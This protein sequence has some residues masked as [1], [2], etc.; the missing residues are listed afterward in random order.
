[1]GWRLLAKY[2][3]IDLSEKVSIYDWKTSR[4]KPR[5]KWLAE[6]V[7]TRLYPYLLVK[8]GAYLRQDQAIQ[9]EQVQMVYWFSEFPDQPELFSYTTIQYETD[10]QH[11][12]QL[13]TE[14][15]TRKPDEFDL[16][17]QEE[18]CGYCMYRSLCARGVRAGA[19]DRA[20]ESESGE[21]GFTFDFEQIAEIEF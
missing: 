21:G 10:E 14:I 6:R 7:Q 9:P 1:M 8:A 5:R 19:L 20:E 2:D 17:A 15:T 16:T 4:N 11:L 3:L 12:T 18:R 13:L